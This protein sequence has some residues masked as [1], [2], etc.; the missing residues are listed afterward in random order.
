MD[1][2]RVALVCSPHLL[3]ES[4]VQLLGN[5][6]EI[7]LLGP[8][9]AR[10]STLLV[11]KEQQPDLVLFATDKDSPEPDEQHFIAN[12]LEAYPDL[13]VVRATLAENCL[14]VYTSHT[15]PARS[16]DLL[17][18]IRGLKINTEEE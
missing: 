10:Q 15:L 17:K 12:I 7:S 18:W 4:L 1:K 3:G 13:P 16:S 11:I 14:R 8:W 2:K 6:D 5:L 9:P